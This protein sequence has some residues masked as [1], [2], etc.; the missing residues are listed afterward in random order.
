[1][2]PYQEQKNYIIYSCY[3]YITQQKRFI[4]CFLLKN[5]KRIKR[6]VSN[7]IELVC[8]FF[9]N[10]TVYTTEMVTLIPRLPLSANSCAIDVSNTRQSEFRIA[11]ATP[12]CI[13]RGIASHVKRLR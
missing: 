8:F 9:E 5:C 2:K 10:K 1:M 6:I 3:L 7:F 11:L 4:F 12:S 13:E